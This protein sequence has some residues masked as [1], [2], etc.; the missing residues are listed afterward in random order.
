MSPRRRTTTAPNPLR[1]AVTCVRSRLVVIACPYPAGRSHLWPREDRSTSGAYD[2]TETA[3]SGTHWVH[4]RR[5][6]RGAQRAPAVTTGCEKPQATD[7]MGPEQ[8]A[9]REVDGVQVSPPSCREPFRAL[10]HEAVVTKDG[11]HPAVELRA[12]ATRSEHRRSCWPCHSCAISS[13]HERYLADSH[14]HFERAVMLGT[15]R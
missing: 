8:A 11:P 12:V 9:L 14:G 6:A 3:A 13:G 5:V 7:R 15:C 2:R 10:A 4:P 1:R